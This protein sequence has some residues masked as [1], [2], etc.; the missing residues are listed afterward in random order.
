MAIRRRTFLTAIAGSALAA[1]ALPAWA[2]Q[3]A[4][5]ASAF[6]NAEGYGLAILN[7][8]GRIERFVPL[9][10]RG[11]GSA[12]SPDGRRLVHFARRPGSFAIVLDTAGRR[13]ARRF[14]PPSSRRFNGHGFFS[15]DGGLLYATENDFEAERGVLGVY[16]AKND[17]GRLGEISTGGVGPHEAILLQS[18]RVAA[19]ANGGIATHPDYP[20]MKLNLPEMRP[21]I[22]LI[23]LGSGEI[24]ARAEA[25]AEWHQVSLRHL[26]EDGH[27]TIWVGGQYEGSVTDKVPLI[28]VYSQETGLKPLLNPKIP[29]RSMNQY[30]G[31]V[32]ANRSGREIALT[33]PRG[34][35]WLIFDSRSF[36]MRSVR[37]VPDVSGAAALGDG[38][39]VTDGNGVVWSDT[40]LAVGD[41]DISWDNHLIGFAVDDL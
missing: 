18:G 5:Y 35:V 4:R 37:R 13:P 24:L 10:G 22:A 41:A 40:A 12:V 28:F 7:A 3:P 39:L 1:A 23:D 6:R 16:D 33:S 26:A 34:G 17:F 21:S 9:P 2:A 19:V 31:S 29:Y 14:E 8:L 36:A 38:F 15:K 11:H 32:A 30:V 27:G 20:R 25:P